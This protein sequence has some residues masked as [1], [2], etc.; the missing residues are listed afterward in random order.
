[1]PAAIVALCCYAVV[2]VALLVMTVKTRGWFMITA[3]VT[4][5]LEALGFVA[6]CERAWEGAEWWGKVEGGWR[7]DL[8]AAAPRMLPYALTAVTRGLLA[9]SL[10]PAP[11]S[12][13]P[14]PRHPLVTNRVSLMNAMFPFT[15]YGIP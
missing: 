9:G 14:F 2:T 6:R 13:C 11:P 3:V 5:A 15:P 10:S 8:Q 7:M 4:G 12:S 1:M